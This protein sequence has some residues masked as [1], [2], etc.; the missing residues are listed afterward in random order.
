MEIE[1][2]EFLT[3][4]MELKPSSYSSLDKQAEFLLINRKIQAVIYG[5][6]DNVGDESHNQI[7]S[8]ERAQSVVYYLIKA[9]VD[10]NRLDA[11]DRLQVSRATNETEEGRSKNRRVEVRFKVK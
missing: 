8:Q 10:E 3:N 1:F 4:S 9:G 6:T 2:I 11:I 7:L 5:H